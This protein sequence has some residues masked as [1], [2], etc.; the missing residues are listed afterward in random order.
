MPGIP[1]PEAELGGAASGG[2]SDAVQSMQFLS[3]D[4]SL[5]AQA[6]AGG[7]NAAKGLF[8][9]KVKKIKVKLKDEYPVLLKINK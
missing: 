1:A 7:V 5:G 4:Q 6:A 3:M 2:A 8:S 9:K